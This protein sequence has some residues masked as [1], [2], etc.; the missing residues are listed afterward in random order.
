MALHPRYGI[1]VCAGYG[2]IDLGLSLA[3]GRQ[4]KCVLYCE[5]E[6]FA[7]ANL[8][9]KMEK[10]SM[11]KAPVWSDLT[12]LP[13]RRVL[14]G[15]AVDPGEVIL[16]G[17]IP[18]QPF[19]CAG[20]RGGTDDAR[21]LWPAFWR[22][23]QDS[24]VGWL[25]LENVRGFVSGKPC[26]L[27]WCLRDLAGS[28]WAAEWDV[29]SARECGAPHKRERVFLLAKPGCRGRGENDKGQ[30]TAS[31]DGV[32]GTSQGNMADAEGSRIAAETRLGWQAQKPYIG[33]NLRERA[34]ANNRTGMG[35]ESLG[36]AAGIRCGGFGENAG[37]V[38]TDQ[39]G[40]EGGM[41]QSARASTY[42]PAGPGEEQHGW[43]P[44]RVVA[45]SK[46]KHRSADRGERSQGDDSET[47]P[48]NAECQAESV[49]GRAA[50]GPAAKLE[51]SV[52]ADRLRLLGNGV[53]PITAALAFRVLFDRINE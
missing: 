41:C 28:G 49:L 21:W 39:E 31:G 14:D 25:F 17:G 37:E 34:T 29:F 11:G 6:A 9:A 4:Y 5:R 20:K 23:A 44:A 53:V 35:Q 2:G 1:S 33:A 36:N 40:T 51:Q 26:G 16:H 3:L 27:D 42:W 19:S 38:S 48:R 12:T 18:C 7:A 47:C 10:G 52:W 32:E 50:D 46:G 15:L 24:G 45:H 13:A 30:P 8:V 22:I 43:E